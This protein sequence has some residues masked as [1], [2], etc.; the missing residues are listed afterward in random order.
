[1]QNPTDQSI[2]YAVK[3]PSGNAMKQRARRFRNVHLILAT[4]AGLVVL[5]SLA[6]GGLGWR[7][8]SQE[9]A[10]QQQQARDALEGKANIL[11]TQFFSRMAETETLL[12]G[13]GS[14]LSADVPSSFGKDSIVIALK[15]G[16]QVQPPGK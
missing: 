11:Q 13:L 3:Q 12:R 4:S 8:L 16:V 9:Q 10:L 1:M 14:S 7:L 2:V 5:V 6:L 15:T